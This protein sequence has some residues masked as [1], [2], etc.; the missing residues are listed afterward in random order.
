MIPYL[1]L[2]TTP[3]FHS[4]AKPIKRC[5]HWS[6]PFSLFLFSSHSSSLSEETWNLFWTML[7]MAS[8]LLI[9]WS[10]RPHITP[11]SFLAPGHCSPYF[12]CF[13]FLITLSTLLLSSSSAFR[14][15]KCWTVPCS[16]LHFLLPFM[17][18]NA[19]YMV[20]INTFLSLIL[21]SNYLFNCPFIISRTSNGYLQLNRT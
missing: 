10:N 11:Q 15:S 6:Y 9:Q 14:N 18:L 5:L 16:P 7:A 13:P 3:S 2:A 17:K 4:T 12:C 8:L 19:I 20:I 1:L 21:S